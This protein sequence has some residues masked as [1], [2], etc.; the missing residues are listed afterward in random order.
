M[1]QGM[2]GPAARLGLAMLYVG[3]GGGEQQ[4]TRTPQESEALH[5]GGVGG[6]GRRRREGWHRRGQ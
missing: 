3:E 1:W 2:P 6:G 5:V 4:N